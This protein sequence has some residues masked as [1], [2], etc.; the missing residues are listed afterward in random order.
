MDRLFQPVKKCS[1]GSHL[2]RYSLV[3]ARGI[4]CAYVYDKCIDKVKSKYR[5]E[6]FTD[7]DYWTDEP[8]EED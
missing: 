2:D 3:D 5:P 6:V 8:V 7:S 4:F 1:C